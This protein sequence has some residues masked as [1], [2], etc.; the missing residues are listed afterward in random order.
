MGIDDKRKVFVY[1][2]EVVL[3]T[4]KLYFSEATL[5]EYLETEGGWIDYFGA[6][7]AD[8]ERELMEME[9]FQEKEEEQYD[10]VYSKVFST[11]KSTE[12]GSDKL[13]EGQTKTEPTVTDAK[14]KLMNLQ[15]KVIEKKHAV[16]ML[17][18]HLR[19]WDKNHENA[20]NRGNTLRK[21]M[22]RLHKDRVL[23][24]NLDDIIKSV[25]AQPRD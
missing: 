2:S 1:G 14:D 3:D 16:N 6:K 21:E 22:E 23:V 17:K 10:R 12:G 13:V 8:A 4:S 5:D 7:L 11:I 20:Q 9:F 15:S 19:A 18:Q 24:D 25:D